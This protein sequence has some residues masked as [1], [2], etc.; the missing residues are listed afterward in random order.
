MDKNNFSAIIDLG[1]SNLR[2]GIFDDN[3][4]NLYSSSKS[5][6]EN[7]IEENFSD[8]LNF[9]IRDAEKKISNHIKNIIVMYDSS[10]IYSIDI[11]LKRSFDQKMNVKK[12]SLSLLT[13]ANQLVK[14]TYISKKIIHFSIINYNIDDQNYRNEVNNDLYGK[15]IILDIKFICLPIKNYNQI[16][17]IFKNN[18][19]NVTDFFCSSYVRSFF[20]LN[21]FNEFKELFFLDIGLKRSTLLR[22]DGKILATLTCI[23]V[24]GSHITKDISKVMEITLEDSEKIK[25][26]FN[27]S[28]TEFAYEKIPEDKKNNLV[29]KLKSKN[30]SVEL[31]KKVILARVEEILELIFKNSLTLKPNQISNSLLVL[32]GNGSKLLKK[33]SFYFEK[34]FNYKEI[35]FFDENDSEICKSGL[36]FKISKEEI[37]L[38]NINKKPKKSGIFEKFFN[39]FSK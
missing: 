20:Y 15:S 13:E 25:K 21:S 30:I 16:I 5:F 35:S 36:N 4:M 6:V 2:L 23:P 19:L 11:S 39:L 27:S 29:M 12:I 9:L 28:E 22:Y 17:N 10:E 32:I 34:R 33:N 7:E 18:N 37:N 1:N 31:L 26:S 24:G 3:Y 8:K 14:N 38:T